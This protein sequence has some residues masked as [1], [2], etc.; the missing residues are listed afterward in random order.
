MLPDSCE[1]INCGRHLILLILCWVAFGDPG[2]QVTFC[3]VSG[4]V[5]GACSVGVFCGH[6]L[7]VCS[8]GV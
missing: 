1:S 5:V 7:W 8:L 2:E 3:E 6:V 4:R